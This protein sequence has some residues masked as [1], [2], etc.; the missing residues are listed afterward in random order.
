MTTPID[1]ARAPDGSSRTACPRC[2][3]REVVLG[4]LT[5]R[6]AYLRCAACAEVWAIPERRK[7]VRVHTKDA[8]PASI[9]AERNRTDRGH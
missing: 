3:A 2:S 5:D 7:F 9:G 4:T 6:F 1:A 8:P